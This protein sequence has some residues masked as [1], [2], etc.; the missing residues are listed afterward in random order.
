MQSKTITDITI[1]SIFHAFVDFCCAAIVYSYVGKFDVE[2][3]LKIVLLYNGI[4]FG[5]QPLIGYISDKT[6][7]VRNYAITGC[8][9]IAF[10]FFFLK[11]P[12]VAVSVAALG[13]AFYHIGGGSA[14]LKISEGKSLLSGIF[15]APGAIGLFLGAF[16]WKIPSFQIFWLSGL[17]VA[18][19]IIIS[20]I[21]EPVDKKLSFNFVGNKILFFISVAL[22][23]FSVSIRSFIG[24]SYDFSLKSNFLPMLL[25]VFSV[26][27]GKASGGWF[28]DKFGMFN[29][30]V[31]AL[32]ISLPLLYLAYNPFMEIA[33]IMLFNFTMPIT[34]TAL[35]DMM[36][37][38]KGFAFGLTTLFLLFGAIIPILYNIK[39]SHDIIFAIIVCISIAVTGIGLKI[40]ESNKKEFN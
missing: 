40:F 3:L 33:G 29:T 20:M 31:I 14:I 36:P 16:L 7:F 35:S 39:V 6:G 15:V 32:L 19:M 28:S 25:F 12:F 30:S 21:E 26:A 24:L 38:K 22:I 2:E 27:F 11:T 34:L 1:Y 23:L 18:G 37:N 9:I 17:M 5:I 10:S 4:A 13:N 8:G